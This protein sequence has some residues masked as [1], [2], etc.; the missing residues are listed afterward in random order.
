[1]NFIRYTPNRGINL[2]QQTFQRDNYW[3]ETSQIRWGAFNKMQFTVQ[4][5]EGNSF[6]QL[7][8]VSV[9]GLLAFMLTGF[10][11]L[12]T[13]QAQGLSQ[14]QRRAIIQSLSDEERQK[15]FGMSQEDKR[16]FFQS[17]AKAA[18]GAGNNSAGRPV[19][20]VAVP[21]AAL[22]ALV[23]DAGEAARRPW[24]NS[25]K[26]SVNLWCKLSRSPVAS[27]PVKKALLPHALKA[28]SGKFWSKSATA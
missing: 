20:P 14:D 3:E 13:A 7:K 16:K 2:P 4:E 27:W 6:G 26:S 25:A 1:M 24:L 15:F 21:V 5:S 23:A 11:T 18:G 19:R 10:A 9:I 17:K 12:H 8:L 22:E 28:A